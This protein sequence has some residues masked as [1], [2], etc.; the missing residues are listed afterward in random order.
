MLVPESHWKVCMLH[1]QNLAHSV[2]YTYILKTA[3]VQCKS[4]LI[5]LIK[6]WSSRKL[7]DILDLKEVG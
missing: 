7:P 1:W 2:Y 6:V 3:L 5:M 4:L